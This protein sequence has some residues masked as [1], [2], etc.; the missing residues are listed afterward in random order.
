MG[1][2]DDAVALYQHHLEAYP[3][4]AAAH[5][6]LGMRLLWRGDA[7]ASVPHLEA[8]ASNAQLFFDAQSN[9]GTAWLRLGKTQEAI[10]AWA[11]VVAMDEGPAKQLY[12]QDIAAAWE[13]LGDAAKARDAWEHYVKAFPASIEGARRLAKAYASEGGDAGRKRMELR[14]EALSPANPTDKA[15]TD[16]IAVSGVSALPA[17]LVAGQIL[18]ADV[19]FSFSGTVSKGNEPELAFHIEGE[20]GTPLPA[21]ALESQPPA[22]GPAPLWRGDSLRQS[23]ALVLPAG[24]APGAYRIALTAGPHTQTVSLWT[25]R[26]PGAAEARP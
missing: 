26:L 10:G 1:R 23:F 16:R 6:D 4:D 13:K 22:L 15:L 2:A 24:L 21:Q 14:L 8:A 19:V 17:K 25:F 11:Q 3:E 5:L 12:W 20:D 18:V 7:A 9:L